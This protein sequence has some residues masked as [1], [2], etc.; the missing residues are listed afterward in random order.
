[1][2][3]VAG[4]IMA[5]GAVGGALISKGASDKNND[6]LKE[7]MEMA[8][9]LRNQN[10]KEAEKA[11]TDIQSLIDD[12]P[13]IQDFLEEGGEIASE[14]RQ[15]RL[16]FLLGGTESS[17]RRAQEIN[18]NL[19][20]FDFSNIPGALGDFIKASNFDNASLTRDAPVG[21][22]ANLSVQNMMQMAQGGLQSSMAIGEYLGRLSGIDQFNPYTMAQDLWKVDAG[23]QEKS[24]ANIQKRSDTITGVNNQWFS[25]F[26]DLSRAQ[27][28]NNSDRAAS[29]IASIGQFSNAIMGGLSLNMQ[30]K[31]LDSQNAY[32]QARTDYYKSQTPGFKLN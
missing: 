18:T 21:M 8:I 24:M 1:M 7:Q 4:G 11:Y 32:N 28:I 27:M 2:G 15:D 5:A 19:A 22:F 3:L 13:R 26:A 12:F 25:N 17:L 20:A 30:E 23:V 9:W 31:S 10:K 16:N 6:L 14:Q 29:Q